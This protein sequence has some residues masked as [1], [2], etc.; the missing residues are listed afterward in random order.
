MII[1]LILLQF[2]PKDLLK[3]DLNI[4]SIIFNHYQAPLLNFIVGLIMKIT[5]KYGFLTSIVIFGFFSFYLIYLILKNL[6]FKEN[7]H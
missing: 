3:N 7:F 6:N 5:N 1:L 4:N 2:F